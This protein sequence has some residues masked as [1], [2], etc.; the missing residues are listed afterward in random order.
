LIDKVAALLNI[1]NIENRIEHDEFVL[2]RSKLRI[3]FPSINEDIAYLLGFFC[4]DGSIAK[5]QPRKKGGARLKMSICF[6][7]S[8]EGRAQARYICAIFKRFFHYEPRVFNKKRTGRKDWLEV[9]INSAV[10]YAYFCILGLPIGEKYGKL[11]VPSVVFTETLFKKFLQGLI[12]SDGYI[13]RKGR[14]VV[15]VQKD[16]NFLNQVRELC[17]KFLNVKFSVP[18]PNSKR[19]GDRTYTWYYILTSGLKN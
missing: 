8:E 18:R 19:V 4:G 10:I 3:C 12:D 5:P 16:V 6:S 15:I 7:G 1:W 2:K 9:E 14:R 17:L 11:K 13:G